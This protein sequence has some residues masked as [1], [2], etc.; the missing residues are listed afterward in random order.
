M[1]IHCQVNEQNK[2][3][4]RGI[5]I[6]SDNGYVQEG[7]FKDSKLDGTGRMLQKS[8]MYEGQWKDGKR[9]GYGISRP[10]NSGGSKYEGHF[11]RD[12]C[13]GHGVQTRADGTIEF[14]GEWRDGRPIGIGRQYS[15]QTGRI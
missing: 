1:F 8:F 13:N 4:G 12:K 6:W 11:E 15:Y 10:F 2:L 7:T 3:W 9:H 14:E 5:C